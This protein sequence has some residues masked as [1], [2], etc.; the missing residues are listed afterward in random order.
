MYGKIPQKM[1]AWKIVCCVFLF[2]L[3]IPTSTQSD[4]YARAFPNASITASVHTDPVEFRQLSRPPCL[5]S[6]APT[7]CLEGADPSRR[8]Q[9]APHPLRLP[10]PA[11]Q[12]SPGTSVLTSKDTWYLVYQLLPRATPGTQFG[13]P[14]WAH[15]R[16][17]CAGHNR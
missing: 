6:A 12:S 3:E 1:K 11:D 7:R 15:S 4:R 2:C 10:A 13:N 5:I 16:Q 14:F 9:V 17:H 8:R